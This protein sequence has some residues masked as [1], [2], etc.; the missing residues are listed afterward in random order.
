MPIKR[1]P[2]SSVAR[3]SAIYREKAAEAIINSVAY[4]G[5][6]CIIES[7]NNG[8]YIDRTGNLRSSIGYAVVYRDKVVRSGGVLEGTAEGRE[9]S[10]TFLSELSEKIQV[11][12]GGGITLVVVAGMNYATYVEALGF[13]VL[14]S[15]KL[16]ADKRVPEILEKLGFEVK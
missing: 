10:R 5:E 3:S 14:A 6:Q 9:K 15:G 13:N 12:F 11:Y 4:V 2:G 16:L 8:K 1:L 7:R